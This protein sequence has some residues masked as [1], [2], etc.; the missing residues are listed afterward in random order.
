MRREIHPAARK[1]GIRLSG[2]HDFRHTLS[3]TLR[4]EGVHPK[5]ISGVLGHSKVQLAL[6]VYDHVD[7]E[8]LRAPMASLAIQLN[9]TEPKTGEAA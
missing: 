1:L 8:E 2:W 3:T 7:T 4:R 9:P 5:L 6:D